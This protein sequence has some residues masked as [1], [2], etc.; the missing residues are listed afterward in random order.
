VFI[1]LELDESEYIQTDLGKAG[2]KN[3]KGNGG[4][5][6]NFLLVNVSLNKD[7]LNS[8]TA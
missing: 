6:D 8:F 3:V 7:F 4:G 5:D 2:Y 1:N